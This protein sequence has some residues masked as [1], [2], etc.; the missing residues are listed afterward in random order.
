VLPLL[1]LPLPSELP[2]LRSPELPMP[3]SELPLRPSELRP[4]IIAR[5]LLDPRSSD[6][7]LDSKSSDDDSRLR[8]LSLLLIRSSSLMRLR[9]LSDSLLDERPLCRSLRF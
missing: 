2:R 9:E 8:M 7:L 6:S 1:L 4:V 3:R 5:S